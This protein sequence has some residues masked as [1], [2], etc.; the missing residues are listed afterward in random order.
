MAKAVIISTSSGQDDRH[1]EI[2]LGLLDTNF[3]VL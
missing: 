1:P 2:R 3:G